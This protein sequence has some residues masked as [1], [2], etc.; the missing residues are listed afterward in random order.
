[1]NA[2][3]NKVIK[4]S[5][6]VRKLSPIPSVSLPP[7]KTCPKD[8]PCGKA[9]ECY[10]MNF[11][12]RR[13]S[14]AASYEKNLSVLQSD[15]AAYWAQVKAAAVANKFFRYHVSG[16]IP[17]AAYIENMVNTAEE[18]PGTSFLCFTKAHAIV[19]DFI[20]NG[21]KIPENLIIIFSAWGKKFRPVNP[22]NFPVAEVVEL[23]EYIPDGWKICGGNCFN[24]ACRGVGCWQLKKGEIIAFKKH[25]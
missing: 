2:N 21:G 20:K 3:T 17:D 25:R 6:D 15:P 9:G 10:V 24:C 12:G 16:D 5:Y 13:P 14:V 1:M 11:I 19:N 4:I 18:F 22:H 7:I 23:G 8:V